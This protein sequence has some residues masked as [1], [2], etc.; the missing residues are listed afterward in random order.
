VVTVPD[1][2]VV[3]TT[4]LAGDLSTD[5][6]ARAFG[7][8]AGLAGGA[9]VQVLGFNFEGPGV[10]APHEGFLVTELAGC[11]FPEFF[12]VLTSALLKIAGKSLVAIT[13][14][15]SGVGLGLLANF[16]F[17]TPLRYSGGAEADGPA[18]WGHPDLFDANSRAWRRILAGWL[19]EIP[20]EDGAP[21]G[22][23]PAARQFADAF[24][25]FYQKNRSRP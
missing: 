25:G 17:G 16:H 13:P 8:A 2:P 6:G 19:D 21:V 7:A 18:D 14:D 9:P 22:V 12:G 23:L 11:R 1:R 3:H 20:Q 24:A 5:R 15:L 10:V 4:V